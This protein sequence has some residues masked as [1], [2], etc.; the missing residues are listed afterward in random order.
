VLVG[1]CLPLTETL[2]LLPVVGALRGY[3]R[4]DK[5][6]GF[7]EVLNLQPSY[8]GLEI[9]RLVPEYAIPSGA[10]DADGGHDEGWRRERLFAAVQA[11]LGAAAAR[12]PMALII[13]DLHWADRSTLDLLRFLLSG[14]D[15]APVPIAVSCRWDEPLSGSAF[16]DWLA[17]ARTSGGVAEIALRPLTPEQAALHASD[18]LGREPNG[19]TLAALYRR[20]GGNPFFTEQLIAA[21]LAQEGRPAMDTTTPPGLAALLGARVSRASTPA[22]QALA[23]LAVANRPI[24]EETLAAVSELEPGVVEDALIELIEARLAIA[25]DDGYRPRHQLL[26]DVVVGN[27]LAA[28][29]RALHARFAQ[30]LAARAGPEFAA[31]VAAHWLAAGDPDEALAWSA[32]AGKAAERMYAYAEAARPAAGTGLPTRARRPV[33]L[34]RQEAWERAN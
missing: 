15:P 4:A 30:S 26:A 11:F 22:R 31:E 20:T 33:L 8:M 9:A 28:R 5:G 21:G 17:A 6:R 7:H 12:G 23:A 34:Q 25:H 1:G 32:T 29:R 24:D 13:E 19:V 14:R 27:L 2:P 3:A 16:H 18:L 10:D